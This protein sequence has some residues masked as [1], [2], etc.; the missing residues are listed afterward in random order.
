[1]L[2]GFFVGLTRR[3]YAATDAGDITMIYKNP[4]RE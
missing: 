3:I 4:R 1:M 2:D